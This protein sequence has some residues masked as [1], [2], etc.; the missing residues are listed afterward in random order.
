MEFFLLQIQNSGGQYL[1]VFKR[2]DNGKGSSVLFVGG[3]AITV[4][5]AQHLDNIKENINLIAKLQCSTLEQAE[6]MSY[7]LALILSG[8]PHRQ[9]VRRILIQQGFQV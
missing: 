4:V 1:D 9:S 2:Y 3:Y 6:N 7:Q 8:N 5:G